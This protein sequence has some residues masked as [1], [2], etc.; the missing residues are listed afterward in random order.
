MSQGGPSQASRAKPYLR[1]YFECANQY[2]RVY[3]RPDER[4]YIARCPSCGMT[5][6]FR[7]GPGGT[8]NR[9]FELT[10]R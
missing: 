3:R 5:K 7:V 10:C 9:F 6:T 8:E 4:S 1:V 2:V